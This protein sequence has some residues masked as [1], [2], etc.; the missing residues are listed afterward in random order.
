MSIITFFKTFFNKNKKINNKENIEPK[1]KNWNL[2][3]SDLMNELK[4]K[5]RNS[6]KGY[7]LKWAKEYELTLIP[8]NYIFPKKGNVYESKM[9]QKVDF[10]VNWMA[11]ITTGGSGLLYKGDKLIVNEN[12]LEDKVI[13]AYLIPI[14]YK[15]IENRMVNE[16]DR[17][18]PKY[19]GF[20]FYFSTIELNEKFTLIK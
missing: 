5:K 14:D 12:I 4:E 15:K 1:P 3:T 6:I 10:I 9:D 8:K 16:V 7:E 19:G 17:K 11:P 13:G 2:T 18:S 20:C